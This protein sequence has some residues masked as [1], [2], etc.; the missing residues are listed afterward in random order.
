MTVA[1][2]TAGIVDPTVGSALVELGYDRDFDEIADRQRPPRSPGPSRP[3]AGGGS[4]WMPAPGRSP[5]RP[6]S[7]STSV[8][9]AKA[10]AAD[11]A[12]QRIA[13]EL[14]CG[15]LVNLG[16]DVAVAGAGPAGAVG[17]SASR[18]KA[19]RPLD[20][21]DQVVDLR[22]GGLATSGTTARSWVRRMVARSTTSSTR[23]PAPR[24]HR[25]G[26]WCRRRRPAASRPTP[27]VRRPW[28]GARTPP[29]T[30]PA[31]GVPARLVGADG[32]V[33]HVGDW[34]SE[35]GTA[36]SPGVL[37]RRRARGALMLT[38]SSTTLWYATRATGI[39]ALVL[40]TLTMVF[41]ILTAGRVQDPRLAGVRPGR[42]AQAGVSAGHGVPG[43]PR[44]HLGPRHLRP[45]GVGVD[46]GS[47]RLRLPAAVDRARYGC[48]RPDG[49]R[50]HLERPAPA[51]QRPHLARHP[52]AG[53]RQLAGG[54]GP[55]ARRGHR[56]L[57]ALDG[58][59]SPS[60]CAWPSA[61]RRPGASPTT[62]GPR[63]GR[64]GSA[65]DPGGAHPAG[66]PSARGTVRHHGHPADRVT[67]GRRPLDE[68]AD[69]EHDRPSNQPI[70][71]SPERRGR[72]AGLS[73][74]L[75]DHGALASRPARIRTWRE[76]ILSGRRRLGAL[77]PRWRR[78]PVGHEVG[79]D[80]AGG[81][82][83]RWWSSTPWR[84]SRPAPRT[85]CCWPA[86]PISSWTAPR[87][88]QR[89]SAPPRS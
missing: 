23:G 67:N 6:A 37:G 88:W 44:P 32:R 15:V 22:A 14:G 40:L 47:V 65:P 5:S 10:L 45:R 79:G 82:A 52:L 35:P 48:G 31:L 29:G 34:P 56:R 86:H 69:R 73:G 80:P 74:H 84:A 8:P 38:S 41:G 71:S 78:L 49:R 87:W 3:R 26:R 70:G 57:Q 42:T 61:A 16:G 13:A 59:A 54:H 20:S 55:L 2:R 17:A 24:P 39:V 7:T 19:A 66:H 83:D 1:V 62:G 53:L 77:R 51:D 33:V 58:R 75:A 27:G 81:A 9:S 85:G 72:R 89:W 50:R 60:L 36:G 11:R 30:W 12:A 4:K 68:G 25:S 18:P 28:C 76:G 21:V 46:R 64:P 63:A 43:H